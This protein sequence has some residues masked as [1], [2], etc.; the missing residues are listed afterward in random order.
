ME[1][2]GLELITRY[3]RTYSIPAEAEI[4]EQMIL[5]HWELERKLTKDLRIE[6][7]K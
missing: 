1:P 2:R 5:D 4:T 6:L 3:K 7:T